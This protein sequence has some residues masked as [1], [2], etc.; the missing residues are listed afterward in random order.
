MYNKANHV[1]DRQRAQDY[2]ELTGSTGRS[3]P[4]E[5]LPVEAASSSMPIIMKKKPSSIMK[6]MSRLRRNSVCRSRTVSLL[7]FSM[8]ITG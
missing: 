4:L 2:R 1:H 5:L 8:V 3:L 6:K 7:S